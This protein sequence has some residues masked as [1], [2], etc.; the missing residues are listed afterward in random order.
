MSYHYYQQNKCKGCEKL[1]SDY[2]EVCTK[3]LGLSRKGEDNPIW[4]GD[5]A[6]YAAIHM[7]LYSNYGQPTTCEICKKTDLKGKRINWANLS[8]MYKRIK[9]DW[10]RMCVPCHKK[11]DLKRLREA[12]M[13]QND[14]HNQI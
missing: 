14:Y 6:K 13:G 11:Y 5:K 10:K 7:W 8:G 1:V 9:S 12:R 2:H 3:C 4:K